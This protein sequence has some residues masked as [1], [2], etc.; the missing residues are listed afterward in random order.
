MTTIAIAILGVWA[1]LVAYGDWRTMLS[2]QSGLGDMV[3]MLRGGP[4]FVA[5]LT[6]FVYLVSLL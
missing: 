2:E 3:A 5:F 1:G 4:A 6:C